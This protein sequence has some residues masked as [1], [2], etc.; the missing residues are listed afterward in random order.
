MYI[1]DSDKQL[2]KKTMQLYYIYE[3]IQ[4]DKFSKIFRQ[5]VKKC[6]KYESHN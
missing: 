6:D 1:H 4:K 2:S 3:R 5:T